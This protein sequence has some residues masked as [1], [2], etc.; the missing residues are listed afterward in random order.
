MKK[1]LR[2][3]LRVGEFKE[4][5]FYVRFRLPEDISDDELD[6]VLDQFI[7]VAIEGNGL[8]FGGGGDTEW[9]GFVAVNGRG[10]VTEDQRE[11]VIA[12]LS[13]NPKIVEHEVSELID[14]WHDS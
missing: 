8:E 7:E 3:K 14:A 9:E 2:K 11:K 6:T 5:G 1:R 13:G 4:L 12:W 10:S